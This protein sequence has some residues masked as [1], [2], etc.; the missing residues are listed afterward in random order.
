MIDGGVSVAPYLNLSYIH[1]IHLERTNLVLVTS[2]NHS[3]HVKV[4]SK[5]GVSEWFLENGLPILEGYSQPSFLP[6]WLI[7][8]GTV[9]LVE[10]S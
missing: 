2:N 6:V 5:P 3:K 7:R 9:L 8:H 4:A 1:E 10:R